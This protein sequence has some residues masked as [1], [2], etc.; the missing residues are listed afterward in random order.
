MNL[1]NL[2][3]QSVNGMHSNK[4]S[5]KNYIQG[6]DF[7]N[8]CKNDDVSEAYSNFVKSIIKTLERHILIKITRYGL[9]SFM[10]HS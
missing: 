6:L 2:C 7:E 4:N 9:N 10:T 5:L 8:I 3:S 1:I